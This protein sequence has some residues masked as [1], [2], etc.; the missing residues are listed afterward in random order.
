MPAPLSV[1][2]RHRLVAYAK[3]HDASREELA[4]IFGVGPATAYRWVVEAKEGKTEPGKAPGAEPLISEEQLHELK[5]L[6]AEKPDATLQELCDAWERKTRVH[7]SVTTMH[8]TLD[9][10]LNLTR[11]KRRRGQRNNSDRT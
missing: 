2:L 4:E 7:V 10:K 6:V 8:R 5:A 11:K 3:K 9:E 1:D